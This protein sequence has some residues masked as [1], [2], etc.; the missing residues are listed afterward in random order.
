M[1]KHDTELSDFFTELLMI[2]K[3]VLTITLKTID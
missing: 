2:Q 3:I 1:K